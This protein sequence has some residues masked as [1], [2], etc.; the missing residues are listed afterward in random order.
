MTPDP[1]TNKHSLMLPWAC[2]RDDMGGTPI[3]PPL[4]PSLP[5][6]PCHCP[7]S[8]AGAH[9]GAMKAAAGPTPFLPLGFSP[10]L[11]IGH[12]LPGLAMVEV[13]ALRASRWPGQMRF[14]LARLWP[15]PSLAGSRGGDREPA[16][17]PM[18]R[19]TERSRYPRSGG[20][21]GPARLGCNNGGT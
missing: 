3:A 13:R 17:S 16:C 20:G 1:R 2:P 11:F 18:G 14:W 6:P 8:L 19:S 15:G 21:A 10:S 12:W 4:V 9:A 7:S 5:S